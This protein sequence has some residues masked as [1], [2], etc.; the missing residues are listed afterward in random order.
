MSVSVVFGAG[1]LPAVDLDGF[2]S[3]VLRSAIPLRTSKPTSPIRHRAAGIRPEMGDLSSLRILDV[4]RVLGGPEPRRERVPAW[5]RGSRDLN[6]RVDAERGVFFDHVEN[7]GGGVLALVETVLN[8]DRAAAL[9]WL[10]EAGFISARTSTRDQR[11]EYARRK[12]S[13]S[14]AADDIVCWRDAFAQ[15]LNA[16]KL[17]AMD[18]EDDESLA[19]AASLCNRIENGSP[20]D[21]IREFFRHRGADPVDVA[22]LIELGRTRE[23]DARRATAEFVLLLARVSESESLRN[24][25]A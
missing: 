1:G 23:R 21:V 13:A 19:R 8:C 6:V 10:E 15:D 5:W 25:G 11:R 7:R 2:V 18:A 9:A 24:V 3:G 4:W 14:T 16:R 12:E 22:R 20:E 17:A